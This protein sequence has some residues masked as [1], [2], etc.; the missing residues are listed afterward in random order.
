MKKKC[1]LLFICCLFSSFLFSQTEE[2]KTTDIVEGKTNTTNISD[3]K[4]STSTTPLEKNPLPKNGKASPAE[5]YI[6]DDKPVDYKTYIQYLQ[7]K[8]NKK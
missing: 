4:S 5:F 7:N 1:F 2:K 8:K 6:I 3:S